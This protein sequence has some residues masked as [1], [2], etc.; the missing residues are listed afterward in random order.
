MSAERCSTGI[1]GFD[2]LCKEGFIKNSINL[3][4]GNAGSGKTTFLL[5]FLYNG[6][7]KNENGLFISFEQEIYDLYKTG[8]LQ[9]MDFENLEKAK[10]CFFLK[11]EPDMPLKEMQKKL[12]KL[13]TQY[14]IKRICFDPI[15]VLSLE[16]PK[17]TNIRKQIYNFFLL[18]KELDS[19]ILISAESDE[20][21]SVQSI[22]ES[23]SFSK[24]L[25]DSVTELFSSGISSSGD[26]ALRI[27]KMRM[28][29]HV[30]GPIGMKIDDNGIKILSN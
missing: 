14:D 25:S 6:S 7:L 5:Q 28:T 15:N 26:R 24:Y 30:R 22:S 1:K 18:I 19:C 3:I 21:N 27:L 23:I 2:S 13:V 17:E 10:K 11:F 12:V 9:G 29:S 16:I 20:S 8:K 4:I